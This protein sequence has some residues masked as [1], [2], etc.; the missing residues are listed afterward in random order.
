M[1][2]PLLLH[3][4]AP[5]RGACRRTE[6]DAEAVTPSRNSTVTSFHPR[7]EPRCRRWH[8]RAQRALA[9]PE[10]GDPDTGAKVRPRAQHPSRPSPSY[11]R[12]VP[13]RKSGPSRHARGR[14]SS[15]TP[16]SMEARHKCTPCSNRAVWPADGPGPRGS[17]RGSGV[18]DAAPP[19]TAS[20][21]RALRTRVLLRD[22]AVASG[23]ARCAA[24]PLPMLL[25]NIWPTIQLRSCS[26]SLKIAGPKSRRTEV[27]LALRLNSTYQ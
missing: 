10:S 16:W 6:A 20:V 4:A 8:V 13:T 26:S 25:R 7:G 3:S 9:G 14:G 5:A 22:A 19:P 18:G 1:R 21:A 15:R 11:D 2:G 24:A 27:Q 23:A 12:R 17:G